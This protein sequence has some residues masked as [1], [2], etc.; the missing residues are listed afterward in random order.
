MTRMRGRIG[1]AAVVAALVAAGVGGAETFT[2]PVGD[3]PGPDINSVEAVGTA[4][5]LVVT[6]GLANRNDLEEDEAVEIDVDTDNNAATGDESGIDLYAVL[7]GGQ[8]PEVDIWKDG[9]FDVTDAAKA[10]WSGGSA[11]LTVPL[12]LIGSKVAV[13]AQAFGAEQ[14]PESGEPAADPGTDLAPDNGAYTVDVPHA[15]VT[16]RRSVVT[17][18]PSFPRSGRKFALRTLSLVLSDGSRVAAKPTSCSATLSGKAFGK[19]KACTWTLP[20]KAKGK[21]L[22]LSIAATYGAQ[23]YRVTRIFVV[24]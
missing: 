2:D 16:L 21:R 3:T 23:T 18:T 15:A 17:F 1:I 24:R 8:D 13:S 4:Q 5:G 14:P 9:D 22:R 10:T 7:V 6:V 11:H 19:G 12:S 20:A